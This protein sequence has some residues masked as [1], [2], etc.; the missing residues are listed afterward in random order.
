MAV[1]KDSR[2]EATNC[3]CV[4][5]TDDVYEDV[6]VKLARAEH[7]CSVILEREELN[8]PGELLTLMSVLEEQINDAHG[9]LTAASAS[10]VHSAQEAARD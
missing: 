7:L 8:Q 6:M 10:T 3:V 1:D 5:L 4:F 2:T 9:F